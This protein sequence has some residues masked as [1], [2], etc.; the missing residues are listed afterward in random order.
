MIFVDTSAL[1]ALG[2]RNDKN[3]KKAVKFFRE[4]IKTTRFVI[5]KHII[6]EYIDG[7]TKRIGKKEA[8]ERLDNILSSK[9]IIIQHDKLKDWE[10][11]IEYFFKYSDQEI[12][13][14]DCLS[15]AMMERL[16]LRTAFTFDSDFKTHGFE[17]VP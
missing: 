8:M 4:T 10:K 15:F 3:H 13:L 1:I 2:D 14:T 11:A 6:V 17:V 9:L 12:D 7:V 5:P 16:D